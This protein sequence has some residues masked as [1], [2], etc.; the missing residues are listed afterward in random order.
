MTLRSRSRLA[1]SR[2][3]FLIGA[4]LVGAGLEIGFSKTGSAEAAGTFV[5]N[6]FIR[7][8]PEGKI[9]L[10]M[11][12]VEMGQGIYTAV[13]MLI[14]EELEVPLD[15]VVLEHAPADPSRYANPVIGEQVTGGSFAIRGVYEPMRRAGAAARIMLINA[16]AREW[17]VNPAGCR[18]EAGVV[19]HGASGRRATYGS[20]IRSAAAEDVP[21]APQLKAAT[22][23]TVIGK[24]LHR[25]DSAEKVNGV[26]M[27]GIDARPDG[28]SYA[29]IAICPT[30]GGR[31][32]SVDDAEA[33]KVKGVTRVV[34]TEN[35][36]A[37]VAQHTGAAH[38]GLA[39][40]KI[41][42]VAGPDGTLSTADLERRM[43]A[44]IGAEGLTH[45]QVGDVA[46]AEA[47][48]DRVH[49][50]VYRLPILAH[51]AMEPMN[52][53]V[54][55]R[56]DGCEVWTG[57]QVMGRARQAVAD[58]TGLPVE[59][60]V[61]HNHLL[62]GGFGRRLDVDGIIA[63][64]M[65]ARQ[66]EG[67]VKVTWSREEDIRH[68]CYRYLNSSKVV[69]TLGPDGMPV[70]W[71][72]R[73]IG[74]SV[75]ARWLPAFT[76]DGIDLD[77]MDG[78][79][80]PYAI[81]NK[82][83]EFVRHEA[84]DGM[85]TGNWRGVG[86]TRNLPAVEG[87]I[88]ELAHVAGI[89]PVDY[90]RRLLGENPRLRRVLDVAAEKA[91]WSSALLP[92]QGRGVALLE[93]FGS[94]AAMVTE[95]TVAPSGAV[96]VDRVVC[97]VDCGQV[98]NPDTVDAQIQSG[99]VYGLSAALYGRITIEKGGVVEG[100]FDDSPVLRMHEMPQV[101][102]HIVASTEAPGGIGEVGTPGVA[103]SLLNAIFMATGKRLRTLPLDTTPLRRAT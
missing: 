65:I 99:I 56:R 90:R 93:A 97:A 16:A 38:K 49:E 28:L 78:A 13:A 17:G 32:G 100:N 6:A 60:V 51:S 24:P 31:L 59:T 50:F 15:D 103:P 11:P 30:F 72:H 5:P 9:A 20:L 55:V 4:A 3:G 19:L 23:F 73:V 42:W 48:R 40:L 102:T 43:E 89:D 54:H 8:P 52:C 88:D 64:A 35:S 76:K 98:I 44:A 101:E 61:V 53:T 62:G 33:L 70:S 87:A 34:R 71:R 74:P 58:A 21:Q 7:I 86:P 1:V 92:G 22:A 83:T 29:V 81:P 47:A 18:A 68:D 66:V 91:G 96:R 12:S 14:A 25:L 26:A 85:L 67:P 46:T 75:M 45:I 2:R 39:A 41:D 95:V 79:D 63:A 77:I 94:F 82:R 84:P 27:F 10:V 80:S 69:A 57:T 37:V 36:V